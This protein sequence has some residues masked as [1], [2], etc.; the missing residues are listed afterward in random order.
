MAKNK[1]V[2]L[3]DHLFAQLERLS[4]EE[5]SPEKLESEIQRAHAMQGIA[6]VIVNSAKAEMQ[7]MKLTGEK[8]TGF[9]PI[10][11]KSEEG[12]K[13]DIKSTRVKKF[14]DRE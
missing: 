6:N 3:R 11:E 9:I 5:L 8:G 12:A 7:Y 10:S 2:D 14:L 4:D 1:I 13:S